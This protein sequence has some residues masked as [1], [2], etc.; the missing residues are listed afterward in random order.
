MHVLLIHQAFV[1][2]EEPGGT[3]HFELARLLVQRGERFTIVASGLNYLTGQTTVTSKR[4]LIKQNVDG[5]N[6]VRAYTFPSLHGSFFWR[7]VSFSSFM[8]TSIFGSLR[9]KKI[10]LVI[11]TSPPIFQAVSAWLISILK[12]KPFLLEVRDLWP[13]FAID[14]GILRNSVLI[15]ASKWLER[16]LYAKATHI[17]VNSPAYT[18]FLVK[19]GV[20]KEKISVIPNGVDP[21]TFTPSKNGEK[22]RQQFG[23]NGKFTVTYAGALGLANDIPTVLRAAHLLRNNKK[24]HFLLVG[25]GNNRSNLEDLARKLKLKNVTFTGAIPKSEVPE[26]LAGSDVCIAT[27]KDIPMFRTTYPNKIFDYMAAGRAVVLAI[28]GVIRKVVESASCGIFVQP[29][30]EVVLAE[31]VQQLFRNPQ[32]ARDMGLKGRRYVAKHF[33]RIQQADQFL[34]LIEKLS[35]KN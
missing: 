21:E 14:I 28:D 29:G 20:K 5:I 16:F 9:V 7:I 24:I 18:D 3:R 2:A 17:V 26:V 19:K 6:V 30:N 12:N 8:L 34:K 27:L 1:S 32:K 22:F 35:K 13:D 25:D 15:R 31:A 23:L 33:N 4:L 11:G 10:D